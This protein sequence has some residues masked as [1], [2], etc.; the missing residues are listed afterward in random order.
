MN[1]KILKPKSLPP[2]PSL[3]SP[4][5]HTPPPLAPPPPPHSEECL[6]SC[7]NF[8]C[9]HQQEL[10][11]VLVYNTTV[12]TAQQYSRSL[13]GVLFPLFSHLKN[14]SFV[15]IIDSSRTLQVHNTQH[16]RQLDYIFEAIRTNPR[17][18]RQQL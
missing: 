15:K 9:Q 17:A 18:T 5:P 10:C 2:F 13:L 8:S 7:P 4:P 11:T 12:H 1:V 3:P 14:M 6:W 16:N